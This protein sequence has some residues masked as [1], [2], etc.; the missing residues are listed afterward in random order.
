MTYNNCKTLIEKN[1]T[2][3]NSKVISSEK[4]QEFK[5]DM[6]KKL[7]V[8]LLNDRISKEEYTELIGLM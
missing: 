8:F 7:D 6:I 2:K 3:L 5:E 4:Y 1:V